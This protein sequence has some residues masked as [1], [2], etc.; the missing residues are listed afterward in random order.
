MRSRTVS[1]KVPHSLWDAYEEFARVAGY[2]SAQQMLIWNPLYGM[3]SGGKH[4][5]TAEVARWNPEAQ[6]AFVERVVEAWKRG[7]TSHGQFLARAIEDVVKQFKLPVSP[8]VVG[9]LVS[10]AVRKRKK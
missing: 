3:M 8:E 10:A 5:I 2:D 6:D 9:T 1:L 4:I 7:E